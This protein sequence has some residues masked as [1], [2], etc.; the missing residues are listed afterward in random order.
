MQN[1]LL[2]ACLLSIQVGLLAESDVLV[3][4]ILNQYLGNDYT[5]VLMQSDL[6]SAPLWRA[7]HEEAPL[8]I[9]SA[10]TLALQCVTNVV[11]DASNWII[12]KIGTER[13]GRKRDQWVYIV[14]F[15]TYSSNPNEVLLGGPH[16]FTLPILMNG[17]TV[18]CQRTPK[19]KSKRIIAPK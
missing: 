3:R 8:S 2:V 19:S 11:P 18:D 15:T 17:K 9:R 4:R 12:N 7:D 14:E 6:D 10:Y 13:L 5:F 16:I 1:L